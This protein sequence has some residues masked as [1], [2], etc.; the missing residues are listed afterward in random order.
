[1]G[2]GTRRIFLFL[3]FGPLADSSLFFFHLFWII[4]RFRL[5]IL[6]TLF[7][8]VLFRIKEEYFITV[9]F[10]YSVYLLSF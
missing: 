3:F 1:V 2:F 8:L 9:V 6:C 4:K 7:T 5:W 10:L